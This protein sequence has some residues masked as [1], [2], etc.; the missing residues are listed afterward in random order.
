MARR[1]WLGLGRLLAVVTLIAIV[2]A[3]LAFVQL[4]RSLP[5]TQGLRTV[6]GL[7]AAVNVER[8]GRGIPTIVG[9]T[10]EDAAFATGFVHAQDRFF[11]MDLLRR[12][13]A[14]EL[15]ELLGSATV[16]L[17]RSFRRHRFRAVAERVVRAMEGRTRTILEAYS[18][19]VNAGLQEQA[20]RPFEYYLLQSKP[21][22][23]RPQDSVLVLLTMF[24]DLQDENGDRES[25]RGALFD[26]APAA[27]AEFLT[28]VGSQ[29]WDAAIDSTT[30][31]QPPIPSSDILD[32]RQR[33]AAASG[34]AAIRSH[35][36]SDG[37]FLGSNNWA[38][39]GTHTNHGA[40]MLA[41]DMHLGLRV[42]SIWYRAQLRWNEQ[43]QAYR[44]AGVTLPGAPAIIVGS[45]TSIAWGYT[46]S[47]GDYAD[48][49]LLELDPGDARRY[50]TPGGWKS[51]ESVEEVIR[52][53]GGDPVTEV[54]QWS[55]WGPVLGQDHAGR[56]RVLRWVAHDEAAVNFNLLDMERVVELEAAVEL[57]PRCGIPHQNFV[58]AH[59]DGDI[60]WTVMGRIPRR[61]VPGDRPRSWA[62]GEG[63]QGWLLPEETPAVIRPASG[64]IWTANARVV[65]GEDLAKIGDDGYALG[66]RAQQIR[67]RLLAMDQFDEHDML[68][69]QLDDEARFLTPWQQLLTRVLE[70]AGD[71]PSR[72]EILSFVR[73]WG[74]RAAVESVGYRLVREFRGSVV[75]EVYRGLTSSVRS[76]APEFDPGDLPRPEGPVWAL[77]EARPAHLTPPGYAGWGEFLIAQADSTADR[78]R[79]GRSSL[80][81]RNWGERNA[82]RIT[83]PLSAAVPFLSSWL[84]MPRLALPGDSWMPRVQ[85]PRHGAS[86]RMVVAPGREEHGLFHMPAGQSGHPMSPHYGDGHTDWAEG[87]PTPFLAGPTTRTLTLLPRR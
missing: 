83:H 21:R 53:R 16:E 68:A 77:L 5:L 38:V 8:D 46:N 60:A 40:A 20:A 37:V 62:D 63:W 45:N 4:R 2:I 84:D 22:A 59:R 32:L 51:I 61:V 24:I 14:G 75:A 57:A 30:Y 72:S 33:R 67:D 18:R 12:T 87:R 81:G 50:R 11:Q 41:N 76:Q 36:F 56:V 80:A 85:H 28:P 42:P 54:V 15:S 9:S 47:Y 25:A 43:G 49:V 10:R 23:W 31:T 3:V 17:D 86:Q 26:L 29:R 58:V 70:D 34:D 27:L 13:S 79:A 78:L 64:R 7:G 1:V 73:Q 39:D 66:A 55:I 48:V 74:G 19:G 6:D 65:G 35:P 69:V 44:L 52:V 82:T 71:T